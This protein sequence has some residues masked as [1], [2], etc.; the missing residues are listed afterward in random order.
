MT[1]A[2]VEHSYGDSSAVT[3]SEDRGGPSV[4]TAAVEHSYGESSAVTS[5]EDRGGP[6]AKTVVDPQ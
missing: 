4:T 6:S 5:S 3:S 2:A 1:T